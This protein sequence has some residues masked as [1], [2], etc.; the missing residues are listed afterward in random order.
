MDFGEGALTRLPNGKYR[1]PH[2]FVMTLKYSGKS[3]RKFIWK[4]GLENWARLHED[5]FRT[6][7]GSV[8]Y[9]VQAAIG[10]HAYRNSHFCVHYHEY[11]DTLAACGW[12]FKTA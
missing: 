11:R 10:E 6:F 4:A 2:L 7:G 1:R 8:Q 3:F 5:A 9:V 12:G